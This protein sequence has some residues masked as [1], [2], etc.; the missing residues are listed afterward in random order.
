MPHSKLEMLVG[1]GTSLLRFGTD[2]VMVFFVLSGFFIHLRLSAD[3]THGKNRQLAVADYLK[4]RA[5]RILPPYY[6]ALLLT[7]LVDVVGGLLYPTLYDGRSG[8]LMLDE[9]RRMGGYQVA[10][11]VPALLALPSL[12]GIRFG[13]NGALW[14]VG[15]EVVYYLLYPAFAWLW[16]RSRG[17]AYGVGLAVSV[18]PFVV[19]RPFLFAGALTGYPL[20]LVGAMLADWLN[21]RGLCQCRWLA[22]SLSLTV[23]AAALIVCNLAG[24]QAQPLL[25]LGCRVAMGVTTVLGVAHLRAGFCDALPFLRWLEMIGTRSYS[26]YVFHTPVLYFISAM[27]FELWG[28]RPAHGWLALAGALVALGVGLGGWFLVERHFMPKRIKLEEAGS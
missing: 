24:V 20:W 16:M 12:L 1:Y 7:V 13:S 23:A 11:V 25:L 26:V 9:K 18:L 27:A 6:A 14:S 17:M 28:G 3:W 22:L 21:W 4:R 10:S 2:S 19:D 15:M 8:D 5:R